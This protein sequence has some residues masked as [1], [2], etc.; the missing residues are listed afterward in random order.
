MINLKI[1]YACLTVGVPDTNFKSCIMKNATE[2]RLLTLIE[3]NLNS[4]E[5]I[6]DYNISNKIMLHRITSSLI[7]FGSSQVNSLAWWDIFKER[8]DIIG[9]KVRDSGMRVSMHPGQYTVL[10]SPNNDVVERSI[11]DL[12]YHT[13]VLDSLNL[14]KE[15]KIILHIGGVYEDKKVAINRFIENYK[16]LDE[17]I[18]YRLVIENDDKSYNIE[19]VLNISSKINIPVI[20]DNLHHNLNNNS[21]NI[22]EN[23]WIE[24]SCKTWGKDDG[25]QKIHYSQQNP[26]KNKGAH[27][28]TIVSEEFI[29]FY[30]RLSNKDIDIMLEV[31]D[32]N[33]SAIKCLNLVSID[34][35]I[36][37]LEL[38]WSKYKYSI[39]ERSATDYK[40]IRNLLKNKDSYPVVEFY[41]IIENAFKTEPS[42]GSIIN[43]LQHVWGYF[44]NTAS[45]REKEWFLKNIELYE[46]GEVSLNSIK[47]FLLRL[48][49]KYD[50]K[51]LKSSYYFS[52]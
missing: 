49:N 38:E 42:I 52:I 47:N 27:S 44:K 2:E 33:L 7:P 4:L 11:D 34:K 35:N 5:N 28:E 48:T 18:K 9:K 22:N 24:L 32:K 26:N 45:N 3:Y 17:K 10:N 6:I 43:G 1:G 30:N 39:L 31:K 50:E 23:K 46:K 25:N 8:F 14:S 20:F 15:H 36:K 19:D 51:Y 29:E 16:K 12:R 21:F 13:M 40:S 41:L 37:K